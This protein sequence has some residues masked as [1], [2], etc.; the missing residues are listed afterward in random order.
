MES[1][2]RAVVTGAAGYIGRH[3]VNAFVARGIPVTAVVRPGSAAEFAE[4]VSV[5]GADVLADSTDVT[6]IVSRD[7]IVVHLAWQD[8]FVH[9]APSH[10]L[11][12][13]DHFRFLDAAATAGASRLVVLGTMHEVGYWEGAI[14][15]DTPTAPR[16]LYGIAKNALREA[17]TAHLSDRVELAW[18]RC[19]YI[20]GDDLRNNSIFTKLLQ[21]AD[22]GETSF[23]FTS[24]TAQFDFIH[25]EELGRQLAALALAAGENGTLNC[26]TGVPEAIGARVEQFIT[27]HGLSIAL[28]YG[29]F[30]DR[31]YDSPAV[32]GD[33]T[34][35]REILAR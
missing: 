34:R 23:P 19:Y 9:S 14:D 10:F 13:S 11:R 17:V 15:S 18:A 5:I 4:G 12:V 7:D 21:A 6:S 25:V 3:V 24:G 33:A 27:E 31:P 22:R 26:C 29:A 28:E 16:S 8:G 35:I 32:W 2:R 1:R 30:P 20:Y